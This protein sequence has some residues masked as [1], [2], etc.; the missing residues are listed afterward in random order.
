[1][2]E[3]VCSKAGSVPASPLGQNI[4]ELAHLHLSRPNSQQQ[5]QRCLLSSAASLRRQRFYVY[6]TRCISMHFSVVA[7]P[8]TALHDCIL[9]LSYD[10]VHIIC[11][12]DPGIPQGSANKCILGDVHLKSNTL[13][14]ATLPMYV[15]TGQALLVG[16]SNTPA[17]PRSD[18]RSDGTMARDLPAFVTVVFEACVSVLRTAS[19]HACFQSLAVAVQPSAASL[20]LQVSEWAQALPTTCSL[21]ALDLQAVHGLRWDHRALVRGNF[22]HHSRRCCQVRVLPFLPGRFSHR[23]SL[24]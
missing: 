5:T 14:W 17:K 4:A 8:D 24:T 11:I 21:A 3:A 10:F 7:Q 23:A 13:A 16:L 1:M 20:C 15:L 9:Y 19:S 12:C 18:D 2:V 22:A 6:V